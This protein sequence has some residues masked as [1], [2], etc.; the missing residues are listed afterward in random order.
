MSWPPKWPYVPPP[1]RQIKMWKK[2][3]T[4][5]FSSDGCVVWWQLLPVWDSPSSGWCCSPQSRLFPVVLPRS[6]KLQFSSTSGISEC[7]QMSLPILVGRRQ[8]GENQL[9]VR[10]DKKVHLI[11][12]ISFRRLHTLLPVLVNLERGKKRFPTPDP[13]CPCPCW[14]SRCCC[15][16]QQRGRRWG[17]WGYL[18][19]MKDGSEITNFWKK[20]FWQNFTAQL[21]PKQ[22]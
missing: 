12:L 15:S 6:Q 10:G 22:P 4:C 13:P 1:L 7:T 21:G 11:V 16:E 5:R 17:W 8:P 2:S 14:G 3:S 20:F 19:S 18:S 9:L